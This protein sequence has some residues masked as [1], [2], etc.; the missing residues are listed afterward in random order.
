MAQVKKE[1]PDLPRAYQ[2]VF[3]DM[4]QRIRTD[5]SR[6]TLNVAASALLALATPRLSPFMLQ[7]LVAPAYLKDNKPEIAQALLEEAAR[8]QR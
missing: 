3:A 6:E 1:K 5:Q 2:L 8:W 4:E 7:L